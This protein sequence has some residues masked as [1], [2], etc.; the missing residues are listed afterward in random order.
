MK[1]GQNITRTSLS[2][3]RKLRSE[4][5]LNTDLALLRA[6]SEEELEQDISSDS[7]SNVDIEWLKSGV[8]AC[9]KNKERITI[10]LDKD[11]IDFFKNLGDGYQTKINDVLNLYVSSKS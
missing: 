10:R 11:V 1:K 5:K 7:D 6:K 8:V 3:L 9:R 4:G 2:E